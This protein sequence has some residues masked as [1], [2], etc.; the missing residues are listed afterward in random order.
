MMASRRS[1]FFAAFVSYNESGLVVVWPTKSLSL[2]AP[3]FNARGA[4]PELFCFVTFWHPPC[5]AS[6][7]FYADCK[8]GCRCD[9][10]VAA[11]SSPPIFWVSCSE[12][13]GV[14]VSDAPR[15]IRAPLSRARIVLS[16]GLMSEEAL[17]ED[18]TRFRR[19]SHRASLWAGKKGWPKQRGE[20]KV[21]SEDEQ[22][23]ESEN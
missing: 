16:S 9:Y 23:K 17:A 6:V 5:L 22:I 7:I 1:S 11:T 10:T 8:R 20:T 19:F 13:R 12:C 4:L 14:Y 18:I 21:R 15:I 2:S 3:S